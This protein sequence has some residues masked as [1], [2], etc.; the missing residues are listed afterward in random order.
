MA[1]QDLQLTF[2]PKQFQNAINSL[3]KS[4]SGIESSL[5]NVGKSTDHMAKTGAIRTGMWTAVM[6]RGLGMIAN[7]ASKIMSK[8]PEIGRSFSIAGDIISRNLL[9]PLRQELIPI[10][11]KMLNWVRDNRAMFV[12]WGMVLA[13]IFR[14]VVGIVKSAFT[15]W[16]KM[17]GKLALG[18]KKVFGNSIK[19]VT[20][21]INIIIFRIALLVTVLHVLIEPIMTF[22][23]DV[24]LKLV[25]LVK[26]FVQG[27]ASVGSFSGPIMSI[28]NSF[29]SLFESFNQ[30]LEMLNGSGGL[31]EAFRILGE[32]VGGSIL[33]TFK[34]LATLLDGISTAVKIIIGA[35][36]EYQELKQNEKM[37]SGVERMAANERTSQRWSD[38][39]STTGSDFIGRQ[40]KA[41]KPDVPVS[42]K[43]VD[44][45][46][47]E[48][49]K[50]NKE[51]KEEAKKRAKGGPVK[52]GAYIVGEKGPEMLHLGG[53]TRGNIVPFAPP[54]GKTSNVQ[55]NDNKQYITVNVHSTQPLNGIDEA[56]DKI[57]RIQATREGRTDSGKR[58]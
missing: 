52:E 48:E 19:S 54:V 10:L 4:I 47:V 22:L 42:K 38:F 50:E 44:K 23:V 14:A 2:D 20:D 57:K 15:I 35:I 30:I 40:K 21:L 49:K 29:K 24:F 51:K 28:V 33:Y 7:V 17:F 5:G 18:L 27:F 1:D 32:I 25:G 36:G 58:I 6:S 3:V 31:G 41:W 13:N 37:Y 55:N 11:Q 8:I 56:V 45:N 39:R 26:Q 43:A 46:G 53:S 34:T 12:K 9:W 16:E